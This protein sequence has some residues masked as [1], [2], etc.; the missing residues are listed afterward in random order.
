MDAV[1]QIRNSPGMMER[2]VRLLLGQYIT[3][4]CIESEEDI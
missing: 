4:L 1:T 2:I 3:R